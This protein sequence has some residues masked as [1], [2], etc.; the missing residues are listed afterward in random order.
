MEASDLE[1]K[2]VEVLRLQAGDVLL[3]RIAR[4][5]SMQEREQTAEIVKAKLLRMGI[6]NDALIIDGDDVTFSV[7]RPDES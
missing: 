1:L 2:E 5:L 4:P 6:E 3:V 7:L